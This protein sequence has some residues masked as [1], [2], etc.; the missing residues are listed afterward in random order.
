MENT[1]LKLEDIIKVTGDKKTTGDISKERIIATHAVMSTDFMKHTATKFTDISLFASP[2]VKTVIGWCVEHYN[3]FAVAPM[4]DIQGIYEHKCATMNSTVAQDVSDFLGTLSET[5][6]ERGALHNAEYESSNAEQYLN[7]QRVN[8][9]IKKMNSAMAKGD[10]VKAEQVLSNYARPEDSSSSAVNVLKD[11]SRYDNVQER[12]DVL[13]EFEGDYGEMFGP[14]CREHFSMHAGPKKSGKSRNI[15]RVAVEGLRAGLS[16]LI[17]SLEMKEEEVATLVD[18]EWLRQ[19]MVS[20]LAH[21]PTFV[22]EGA[23]TRVL[24]EDL[25]K[26]ARTPKEMKALHEA[27]NMFNPKA[28]LY[29]RCWEQDECT[30]DGHIIPELDFIRKKDDVNFDLICVDYATIM[31][32]TQEQRRTDYRHQINAKVMSLKKLAQVR[33]C[34]VHTGFQTDEELNVREDYRILTHV[35]TAIGLKQ[36]AEEKKMGIYTF[37]CITNRNVFYD[38]NR[39]LIGLSNHGIGL[40][41]L[42]FRWLSEA[43]EDWLPEVAED[44]KLFEKEKEIDYRNMYDPSDDF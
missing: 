20:G 37:K 5:Y 39:I 24:F 23:E 4:Q 40:P 7:I 41:G 28:N 9:T 34:H 21:I 44:F 11:F 6:K 36:G 1:G 25:H 18:Q 19:G 35:N 10:V 16:V 14:V 17:C 27:K 12:K 42:D 26:V 33:R 15:I 3:E 13:F 29:I 31:G 30:V 2:M 32:L 43:W 38:E 22:G 8:N